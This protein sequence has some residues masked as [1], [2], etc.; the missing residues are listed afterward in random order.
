MRVVRLLIVALVV[1]HATAMHLGAQEP[2]LV[3]GEVTCAECVITL[4]TVVT[5]GG[6]DGPGLDVVSMFSSVAVDR[7]GRILVAGESEISVFDSTGGFLRTVGRRG[8]GPGEYRS[9]SHIV[10]GSRYIHVFE[11]HEGRTMLDHDF[12]VIRVDQFP[13]QVLS[14]AVVSDDVVVFVADVPTPAA[15]GHQLHILRPSGE[16]ASHGYDGG[17]YSSELAPWA[18][19]RTTV[20]G[21]GD[22]VWA[23]QREVNRLVRWDLSP[24]PKV[25]RVFE[26]RV[27]EFDEGGDGFM[28]ATLGSA[29]L[30]DRGLWI[31]WHTADPDWTGPPPSLETL[32]PSTFAVDELRDGWVDLVDPTTG[33]TLARY[34]QDNALKGFA[35]GSGRYVVDY[36]ETDAG[37]P[38]IHI[39]EL[40]LARR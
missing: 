13:G 11:Y 16:L 27:A 40:R 17:V 32:R 23:V 29:M 30:D 28:P 35:A 37:V 14:A 22:T 7:R 3:S 4:D 21:R 10:G 9:I 18:T 6:L 31:T 8:E 34:H 5:I 39:L 26:R 12:K 25:G 15:V 36:E 20:A 1:D 19:T 2:A 38:F 33:R 24:E